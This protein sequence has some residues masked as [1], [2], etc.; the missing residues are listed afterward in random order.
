MIPCVC[1]YINSILCIN[2]SILIGCEVLS[3]SGIFSKA[4]QHI[5]NF[6]IDIKDYLDKKNVK[7]KKADNGVQLNLAMD[8]DDEF[9]SDEVEIENNDI[10]SEMKD[11]EEDQ[12]VQV[13]LK[14]AMLTLGT[15]LAISRKNADFEEFADFIDDLI[16]LLD[17][18]PLTQ[19]DLIKLSLEGLDAFKNLSADCTES[20]PTMQSVLQKIAKTMLSTKEKSNFD[21]STM[22]YLLHLIS[23]SLK[24]LSG[25]ETEDL[26]KKRSNAIRFAMGF[27]QLQA[28]F[29]KFS[30]SLEIGLIDLLASLSELDFP[31]N[32]AKI[33]GTFYEK[34]S[35]DDERMDTI[36]DEM[37]LILAFTKFTRH[38]SHFVREFAIER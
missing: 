33:K 3:S 13:I 29:Q 12:Q 30:R 35:H 38:P 18:H 36:E 20:N 1:L 17:P 14:K 21:P 19:A 6:C 2:F 22:K 4:T 31:G 5:L 9:A 24:H 25:E 32:W 28:N 23:K 34:C 27:I 15:C 16:N 8:S 37:A 26:M 7:I 11:D 10:F